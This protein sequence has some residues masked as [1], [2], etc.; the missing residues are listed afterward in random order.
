MSDPENTSK[1]EEKKESES[2]MQK[3]KVFQFGQNSKN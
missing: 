3:L 2:L 1:Q